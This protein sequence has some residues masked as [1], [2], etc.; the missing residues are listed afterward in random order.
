[1]RNINTSLESINDLEKRD[2]APLICYNPQTNYF[3]EMSAWFP[4]F[5]SH[6]VWKININGSLEL[7]MMFHFTTMGQVLILRKYIVAKKDAA[8]PAVGFKYR[9]VGVTHHFQ[10]SLRIS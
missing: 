5:I 7:Y 6:L 4:S 10:T 8:S 9:L 1:M 2:R 3:H